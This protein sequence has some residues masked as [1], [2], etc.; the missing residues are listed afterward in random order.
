VNPGR[1]HINSRQVRLL[2]LPVLLR[3]EPSL[4]DQISGSAGFAE[5][6]ES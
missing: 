1:Q 6:F 4:T 2:F 5:R 3:A